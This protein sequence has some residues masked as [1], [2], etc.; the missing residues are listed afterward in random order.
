[1]PKFSFDCE[2]GLRFSR[3]LKMGEHPH[4]DCPGCGEAAPRF[5][6]GQGFSHAFARGEGHPTN[7]GVAKYDNPNADEVVGFSADKR[8][9]EI[10]E[11]EKVK[12]K[13]REMGGT[14]KL[15]RRNA[16]E[17]QKTGGSSYVE[18]EAASPQLIEARKALVKGAEAGKWGT[19]EKEAS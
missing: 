5:W 12:K 9:D 14:T 11:R 3:T 10:N 19:S 4:H 8:W 15:I 7:S 13:V 17:D 1:M 16:P 6:E 2:C 18:Y